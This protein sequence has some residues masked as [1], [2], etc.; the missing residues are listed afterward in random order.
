M[1]QAGTD[2]AC[3]SAF[4]DT[5]EGTYMKNCQLE[6]NAILTTA[7]QALLFK[8]DTCH[9]EDCQFGNSTV[10]RTAS[11]APV[12]IQTPA[13]YSYFIG[14]NIISYNNKKDIIN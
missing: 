3:T 1:I 10:L 8:G 12:V 4:I 5:G 9:Y 6:V 2:V 11:T 14:C 13:R 7:A